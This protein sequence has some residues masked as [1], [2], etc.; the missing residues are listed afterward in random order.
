MP[1]LGDS[2][3]VWAGLEMTVLLAQVGLEVGAQRYRRYDPTHTH[4]VI[5]KGFSLATKGDG[6]RS[7]GRARMNEHER[8]ELRLCITLLVYGYATCATLCAHVCACV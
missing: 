3:A 2:G 6:E 8:V 7:I 1:G 5:T 4:G